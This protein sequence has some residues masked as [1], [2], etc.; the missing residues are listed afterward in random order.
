MKMKIMLVDPYFREGLK[1]FPLG[2]AYIAEA[3]RESGYDVSVYDLTA[4]SIVEGKDPYEILKEVLM[5]EEPNILG[6]TSTSPTHK[7]AL[8]VAEIV[9][10]YKDI[11]IIKGGPHETNTNGS[12]LKRYD[13]DG[14][15]IYL[16]DYSI[17]GE[18]EETIVEL[19]ERIYN[20][21]KAEGVKGVIYREKDKI[22]DNGR[23][24]LIS[25]LDTLPKPARDLFYIDER[26]AQ[27]YSA[28]IFGGKKSTSIMSSRGCPYICTYCSST[29][30]W[31]DS[32][33]P[34]NRKVR[35]RS[36]ES[37]IQEI[38]E[39]YYQGFRGFMFED[40]MSISNK[41]WFLDFA[42]EVQ[43]KGLNIEYTLQTRVDV[44]KGKDGEKIAKA[45]KES[46]CIFMYFGIES[47]V[48]DILNKCKKGITIEQA[49][50]AFEIAKK[51]SIRTMASIQ[52]GL[53]GEDLENFSTIQET[54]KVLNER[55][56][57]S[58]VAISP[59]CLY[60]GS[61]LA[62]Q[63]G[64]TPEMYE[65]YTSKEIDKEMF[66]I[67]AHGTYSIHPK[68]LTDEKIRIIINMFRELLSPEIKLFEPNTFYNI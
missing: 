59:T 3:L 21:I 2:L 27:Y 51:Y 60:P 42:R 61:E 18:G 30:N 52:F 34:K 57:P 4:M 15:N 50:K 25:N 54:I 10:K 17:V 11:P 56:K 28:S 49:E 65:E 26:Y 31:K 41:E 13:V 68:E 35:Q 33:N 7:N 48:Q 8:K 22:I 23:R 67:T 55:L 14:E 9:K 24:M 5:K 47:G 6:I 43:K 45:L 12:S 62:I 64:I 1:G 53:P 40:D 58:E 36:V 32:L 38:E 46:G 39:L 63:E 66:K 19:L 44:F 37:V 29:Q 16:I 20:G